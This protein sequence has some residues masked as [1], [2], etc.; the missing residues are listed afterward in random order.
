MKQMRNRVAMLGLAIAA[1]LGLIHAP[2]AIADDTLATDTTALIGTWDVAL[3]FSP[4][5]PPSATVMTVSAIEDGI[6]SGTFYSTAFDTGRVTQ[7]GDEIIFVVTT[8]DGTG[9]YTTSGRLG[10][11]DTIQ[12]QTFAI[13]RD[14][15]MAWSAT[16]RAADD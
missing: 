16:R 13:G 2:S 5:E 7:H 15:L 11:D 1:L 14:F 10:P 3:Y 4:T 12:G 8:Q 9:L 6:L